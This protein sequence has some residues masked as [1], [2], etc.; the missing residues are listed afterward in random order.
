M[1]TKV[2]FQTISNHN[3]SYVTWILF[4]KPTYLDVIQFNISIYTY[5]RAPT[6]GLKL[7]WLG[8]FLYG[9]QILNREPLLLNDEDLLY[10]TCLIF[11]IYTIYR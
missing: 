9:S 11:G 4:S 8:N 5:Y 6:E 7:I 10:S 3:I 1:Q 2:T